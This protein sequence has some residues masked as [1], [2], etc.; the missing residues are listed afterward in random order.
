MDFALIL[1]ASVAACFALRN[2]LK[3]CPLA[4]YLAAI[5]VDVLYVYGV[6]FGLPRAVADALPP[7]HGGIVSVQGEKLGV[8]KAKNGD[9]FAIDPRCPHLGCQ[10]EWN[11]DS[12]SWECPCHG[13]RFDYR[14]RL[15]D[16]PAQSGLA[17]EKG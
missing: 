1:A 11:P 2:P 16:G 10:L 5:A 12:L 9:T 6:F 8:H 14:G 7:G 17:C 4:F 3:A 15:L 13:S